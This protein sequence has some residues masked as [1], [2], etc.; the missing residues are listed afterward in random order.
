[1]LFGTLVPLI[2]SAFGGAI[3]V[4]APYFNTV[5]GPLFG[6]TLLVVPI[7]PMLAWKRGDLLGALERLWAVFVVAALITLGVA[8]LNGAT[9]LLAAV[10]FGVAAWVLT[11]AFAEL[12]SRARFREAGLSVGLRRLAGLPRSAF[13]TALAHAGLGLTLLG[14][15][16]TSAFQSEAILEMK[17]GDTT[18][19]GSYSVT[20]DGIRN[21]SGSNYSEMVAT[22]TVRQGGTVRFVVEPSRRF[23][24]TRQMPTTEAGIRTHGLSQ[25]Y[26]TLGGEGRESGSIVVRMWDKPLVTLIWGGA[27]VMMAG[28]AL[29]L[30]DR[31]LRVGA[32]KP[33]RRL[34]PAATTD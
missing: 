6:V 16:S 23:Y 25:F 9:H 30:A 2:V 14:I 17:P 13:G 29:S 8:W 31:R 26:V 27:L 34:A 1:V 4:G 19:L 10:G 15:V 32:P 7:G 20:F 5:F 28:G 3:S 18:T 12:W 22:M 21:G 24:A 11:G 33:A